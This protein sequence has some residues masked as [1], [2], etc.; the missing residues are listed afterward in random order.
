M[1]NIQHIKIAWVYIV[2][3]VLYSMSVGTKGDFNG[4]RPENTEML[5]RN[6]REK[7]FG[8]VNL[9]IPISILVYVLGSVILDIFQFRNE[10]NGTFPGLSDLFHIFVS[11]IFSIIFNSLLLIIVAA[12]LLFSSPIFKTIFSRD[13][14]Y[15][16][17]N[18]QPSS[19]EES[20]FLLSSF[21]S[22]F[23]RERI[24]KRVTLREATPSIQ[25][26]EK[27]SLATN[28]F[29]TRK[30]R[31]IRKQVGLYAPSFV[32]ALY[33]NIDQSSTFIFYSKD[34]TAWYNVQSSLETNNFRV[35]VF[36]LGKMRE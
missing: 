6:L 2:V 24:A 21:D 18:V 26:Q 31:M 10:N 8:N 4:V 29:Q 7:R 20:E 17:F 9:V 14:Y 32:I 22:L 30:F 15:F 35:K 25:E 34:P 33:E 19:N 36:Q 5:E 11:E 16:V 12:I 28:E 3:C 13:R 1:F 27:S 23:L